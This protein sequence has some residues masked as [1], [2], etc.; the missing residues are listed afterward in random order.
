[1]THYRTD[2]DGSSRLVGVR[3][4]RPIL[5]ADTVKSPNGQSRW[6][7]CR[8]PFIPRR[9]VD[10]GWTSFMG[11]TWKRLQDDGKWEYRQDE[12]TEEDFYHRQW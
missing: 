6:Q 8:T 4:M 9:T 1:M 7:K 10:G 12:E 3:R 11:Q 2:D 5:R